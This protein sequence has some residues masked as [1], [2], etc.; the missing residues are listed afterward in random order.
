MTRASFLHIFAL[1]LAV[2][3]CSDTTES[4]PADAGTTG[5]PALPVD[6]GAPA[7]DATVIVPALDSGF[8][9]NIP[10]VDATVP[11]VTSDAGPKADSGPA[12]ADAG[13]DL[14]GLLGGLGGLLGGGGDSG[15]PM[16]MPDSGPKSTPSDGHCENRPC[17]DVFD[18]YIINPD[19]FD[20][21][22]TSCDFFTCK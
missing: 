13:G 2:G 3:A 15:I 17:F 19:G 12:T 20:C 4:T 7:W 10:T 11:V 18:C 1:S 14:G 21:G 6:S 9:I 8:P 5:T 16:S 22:W